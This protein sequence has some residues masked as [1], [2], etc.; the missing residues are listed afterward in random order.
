MK[1]I[2]EIEGVATI[3]EDI[4]YTWY[5]KSYNYNPIEQITREQIL[6][7]NIL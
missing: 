7:T 6:L 5:R 2:L 1:Q 3:Q 4:S